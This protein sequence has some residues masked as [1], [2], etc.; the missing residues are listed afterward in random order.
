MPW[1][2]HSYHFP[3]IV[4]FLCSKRRKDNDG[5]EEKYKLLDHK[6]ICQQ[7]K[8]CVNSF[9]EHIFVCQSVFF[10]NFSKEHGCISRLYNIEEQDL[11][12]TS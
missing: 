6:Y 11:S 9:G 2:P 5:E 3:A 8:T 12:K 1:Q 7:K 10:F 4:E